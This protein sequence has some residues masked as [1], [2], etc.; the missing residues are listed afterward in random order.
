MA[1]AIDGARTL[2]Q[3]DE[4]SRQVWQGPGSGDPPGDEAQAVVYRLP[5]GRSAIPQGIL[6]VGMSS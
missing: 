2:A 5:G 1:D 3:L 6:P 4:P